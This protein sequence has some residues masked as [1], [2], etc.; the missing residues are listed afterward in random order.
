[1]K[2]AHIA[3][4]EFLATVATKGFLIGLLLSP[5]ITPAGAPLGPRF[6]ARFFNPPLQKIE[7]DLAV[8]D[9]PAVVAPELRARLS[10]Q[11]LAARRA[12]TA[13]R[14]LAQAPGPRREP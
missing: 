10:P 2:I 6:L 4:R 12:Q 13:P 14:A 1:M 3:L 9:P 7:A 8:V 5:A 11:A